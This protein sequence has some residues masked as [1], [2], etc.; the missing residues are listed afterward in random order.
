MGE[1]RPRKTLPWLV[2]L[3]ARA[4]AAARPGRRARRCRRAP[5]C[6]SWA[7]TTCRAR[8]RTCTSRPC[9]A[10]CS[11]WAAARRPSRTCP[12]V[13]ATR[14]APLPAAAARARAAPCAAAAGGLCM[15]CPAAAG[16]RQSLLSCLACLHGSHVVC[17]EEH[18]CV[19]QLLY[20]QVT[21]SAVHCS[22]ILGRCRRAAGRGSK[23]CLS[24]VSF[25][26][27]AQPTSSGD[28]RLCCVGR[29]GGHCQSGAP[30]VQATRWPWW[31][32]TSS[33]PRTRH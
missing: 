3:E 15:A 33:S 19:E 1:R 5:R 18:M 22:D 13:R 17:V 6:A 26:V 14:A 10:P 8:R 11:A 29:A 16:P 30:R 7:P 28:R 25:R 12:A 23:A 9:S 4:D 27:R 24:V 21:D 20:S 31:A 32:W 2:W